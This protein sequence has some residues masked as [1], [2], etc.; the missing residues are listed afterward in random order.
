MTGDTARNKAIV[1]DKSPTLC[2]S[3]HDVQAG[4]VFWITGLSG[5]GK[6]TVGRL[7]FQQLRTR[8][9]PSVFLDGDVLRDVF[10]NN[11]GY[12]LE[13]R[14]A[15]AR[16]Y[17]RLSRMLAQQGLHV[18]IATISMFHECRRWNR[19]HIANYYEIYLRAPLDLLAKRDRGELY[20]QAFTG[21]VKQVVGVDLPFEEPSNPDL[22]IDTGHSMLPQAAADCIWERI[23]T[24]PAL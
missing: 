9:A 10:E 11:L 8:Y 24:L 18:V 1:A 6:T 23:R 7:I 13:E 20:R 14:R 5:S 4:W 22:I 15:C 17:C 12:S 21:A 2:G 19:E 16:R 3:I